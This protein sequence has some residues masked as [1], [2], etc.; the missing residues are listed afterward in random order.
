MERKAAGT[1]T[2][3]RYAFGICSLG[4]ILVAVS[5]RGVCAISLGD[6]PEAL[7]RDLRERLPKARR[8]GGDSALEPLVAEVVGF[9][10]APAQGLGLPL[11]IRGTAFQYRV[12]R[13]LR[14]IPS[15]RQV[16]YGEIARRI[17]AP[18]A[19]RAV[20]RACAANPMAVAIPCHRVGRADGHRSGYRWGIERKEALLRRESGR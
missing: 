5:P 10:E 1:G 2:E 14:E 20:A 11:D 13:A 4:S 19:A 6:D 7:L 16:S 15:G 9:I 8:I 12:W 18:K 17:G 3:I